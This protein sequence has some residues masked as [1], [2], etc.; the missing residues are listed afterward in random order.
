MVVFSV[1]SST[2]EHLIR[3]TKITG[4]RC[5]VLSHSLLCYQHIIPC[6]WTFP[7][8]MDPSWQTG[9]YSQGQESKT[10]PFS[11]LHWCLNHFKMPLT[12]MARD[13]LQTSDPLSRGIIRSSGH[14]SSCFLQAGGSCNDEELM[15]SPNPPSSQGLALQR[16]NFTQ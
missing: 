14:I 7:L 11:F 10:K 16:P 1:I 6:S 9:Q 5:R 15:Q 2:N 13:T 12:K 3:D 4:K 8:W